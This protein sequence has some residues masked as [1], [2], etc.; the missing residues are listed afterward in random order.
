VPSGCAAFPAAIFCADFDGS[1]FDSGFTASGDPVGTD[2]ALFTSAPSA[3]RAALPSRG[4][5]KPGGYLDHELP[6][7]LTSF[8]VAWSVLLQDHGSQS[9]VDFGV[10][11]LRQGAEY[12]SLS[13]RY[14]HFTGN[15]PTLELFEYGNA[16][17]T[18]PQI[19]NFTPSAVTPKSTFTRFEIQ[20]TSGASS[21]S[22]TVLADGKVAF[23]SVPVSLYSGSTP[24]HIAAGIAGSD[25]P[26]DDVT[27]LV[28]D[29]VVTPL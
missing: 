25:G 15:G 29:I 2:T 22:V 16:T 21:G 24:F 20:V 17:P 1:P 14:Q 11:L 9:A 6:G 13:V 8:R 4:D 7:D 26:G 10:T 28:D 18:M 19:V 27:V 23:D 5:G 12:R 3:L